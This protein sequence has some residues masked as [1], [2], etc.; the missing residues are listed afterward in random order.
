VAPKAHQ[1]PGSLLVMLH[2]GQPAARL[3][4]EVGARL[5]RVHDPLAWG[6]GQQ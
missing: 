5:F 4:G 2:C 1:E 6:S 3:S